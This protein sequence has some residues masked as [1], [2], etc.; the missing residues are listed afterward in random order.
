MTTQRDFQCASDWFPRKAALLAGLVW[1]SLLVASVLP[2]GRAI[3]ATACPSYTGSGPAEY[4]FSEVYSPHIGASCE[5]RNGRDS[6]DYSL[7]IVGVRE[8][9]AFAY[10]QA[11]W[12]HAFGEPTIVGGSGCTVA[13][14]DIL[15][16]PGGNC[17]VSFRQPGRFFDP[18]YYPDYTTLTAHI[19]LAPGSPKPVP[20]ISGVFISDG[21]YE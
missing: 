12:T 16:A 15:I 14:Y 9:D 13:N 5:L 18:D 2:G 11:A 8:N 3:A 20:T 19:S 21:I 6:Q 4:I 1:L 17:D 7:F 10:M